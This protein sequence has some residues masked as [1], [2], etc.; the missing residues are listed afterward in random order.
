[1]TLH[2]PPQGKHLLRRYG[3]YSSRARGTWKKRPA[4]SSRAPEGW[5]GHSEAPYGGPTCMSQDFE[6]GRAER[7][8]TWARLLAKVYEV[9]VWACP[10]CGGRMSVIAIIRDPAE[11]S[12]IA[13]CMRQKGRG[14]P[15]EC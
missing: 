13:A 9:D 15:Y 4:L 2:I 7:K 3:L 14:P 11:I 12:R 1:M 5:Y 10:D 6:V 8:S